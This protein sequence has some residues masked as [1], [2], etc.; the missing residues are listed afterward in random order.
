MG[1]SD[2]LIM[3]LDSHSCPV[4]HCGQIS[5]LLSKLLPNSEV[6][7]QAGI[8]FPAENKTSFSPDLILLKSRWTE[9]LNKAV[10][11]IAAT[12]ANLLKLFQVKQ[13]ERSYLIDILITY[14][15]DIIWAV[16]SAGKEP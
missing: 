8:N 7:L 3:D 12:G 4:D 9:N 16:K 2:I 13:F 1:S 6:V 10:R 14:N 5:R 11:I 15:G